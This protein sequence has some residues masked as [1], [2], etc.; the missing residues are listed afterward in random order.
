[1]DENGKIGITS[2]SVARVIIGVGISLTIWHLPSLTMEPDIDKSFAPGDGGGV[3]MKW[4]LLGIASY[5][6]GP[7]PIIGNATK[8]HEKKH[9]RDWWQRFWMSEAKMEMRAFKEELKVLNEEI[10]KY[11][12]YKR[13]YGHIRKEEEKNLKEAIERRKF[14]LDNK[15]N[16]REGAAEYIRKHKALEPE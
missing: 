16:T 12:S 11:K 7:N 15:F 9:M 6:P 4:K 13:I 1:M 14:I 10:Y 5:N 3:G 8:V 2:A